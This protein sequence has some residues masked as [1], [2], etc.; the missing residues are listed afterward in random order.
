MDQTYLIIGA[1]I[2]GGLLLLLVFIN[3]YRTE[4]SRET[5]FG[6][7]KSQGRPALR[8]IPDLSQRVKDIAGNPNAKIAA[9]KA[10]R[11]E[12]GLGLKEAKGAVENWLAKPGSRMAT[13]SAPWPS[14][15][16]A[17]LSQ[18]VKDIASR[19]GGKIAAIKAYRDET[20]AG[21]KDAKDAVE[22]WLASLGLG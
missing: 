21:L 12:T 7:P 9:I 13:T 15:P 2:L 11:E 6:T 20:G 4:G 3:N 1:A 19:P 22:G 18:R 5:I 8:S 16:P 10:Y 14:S 17:A